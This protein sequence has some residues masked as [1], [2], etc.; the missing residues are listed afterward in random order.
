MSTAGSNVSKPCDT[1]PISSFMKSEVNCGEE[2]EAA[3]TPLKT[4]FDVTEDRASAGPTPKKLK[5]EG[6]AVSTSI[7]IQLMISMV[8]I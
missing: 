7:S 1:E 8:Y 4:V 3:A 2:S 5:L 6:G